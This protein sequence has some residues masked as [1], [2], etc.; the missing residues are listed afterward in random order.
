M[1]VGTSRVYKSKSVKLYPRGKISFACIFDEFFSINLHMGDLS[2]LAASQKNP[3]IN[4]RIFCQ[5]KKNN[6]YPILLGLCKIPF[7]H[8]NES[9]VEENVQIKLNSNLFAVFNDGTTITPILQCK[10]QW[11]MSMSQN[12]FDAIITDVKKHGLFIELV[13]SQA[14]GFVHI[15]NL[16]KDMYFLSSNEQNIVGKRTKQIFSLGQRIKVNVNKVD[17]FKR[18][19]D[20][21]ISEHSDSKKIKGIS[22]RKGDIPNSPKELNK[23]RKFRRSNRKK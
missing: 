20:F 9:M 21:S 12:D 6:N 19:L 22:S 16:G 14:F 3:T 8:L 10:V 2:Q 15:S 11:S 7:I 5:Q 1:Q 4:I 17:R 18:Q 13:D 23:L